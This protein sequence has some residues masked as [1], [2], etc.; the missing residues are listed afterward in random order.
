MK[1]I[2]RELKLPWCRD[3]QHPFFILDNGVSHLPDGKRVICNSC[4]KTFSNVYNGIR[5]YK[6]HLEQ[7]PTE[8]IICN[9]QFKTKISCDKHLKND[10][11]LKC[12]T[13]DLNASKFK[14]ISEAGGLYVFENTKEVLC[15]ICSKGFSNIYN[16]IRHFKSHTNEPPRPVRTLICNPEEF[17]S[18]PE[19]VQMLEVP[20]VG[21]P[22]MKSEKGNLFQCPKQD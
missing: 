1:L 16:G 12:T 11:K 7:I 15:S 9:Q 4:G 17:E 22:L 8:C 21:E 20:E 6:Q 13:N 2:G 18:N 14:M 5:H 19:F 3:L 10:H